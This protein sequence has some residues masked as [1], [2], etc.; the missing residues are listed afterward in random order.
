MSFDLLGQIFGPAKRR[1]AET[2]ARQAAQAV[3]DGNK[4]AVT[5]LVFGALGAM[6]AGSAPGELRGIAQAL[7]SQALASPAVLARVPP[8][9]RPALAGAITQAL[10]GVPLPDAAEAT[11]VQ[12]FQVYAQ[13]AVA[14]AVH[15]LTL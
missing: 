1:R 9:A 8:A 11:A 15:S 7:L 12:A 13:S 5:E 4:G 3:F 14:Q 10:A 6:P 2:Q